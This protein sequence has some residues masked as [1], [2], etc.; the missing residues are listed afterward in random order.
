MSVISLC[1]TVGANT[2]IIKCDTA[3]GKPLVMLIGGATFSLSDYGTSTAF[4]TALLAAIK[5]ATGSS[6]KLYPFPA[7]EGAASNTEANKTATTGYGTTYILSEGRPAYTFD[8]FTG[9]NTE[10]NLRKFNKATVPVFIFDDGGNLWGKLDASGKF[11]GINAQ[12]FTTGAGFND[13][14]A[15]SPVKVNVNFTSASDFFDYA[16]YVN[17]D[18]NTSDLEGLLDA[19]LI[20]KA[21]HASSAYK[22]GV[23]VKNASLGN[24][25]DLYSTYADALAVA[26][27]WNAKNAATGANIAITTVAKDA[28]L[29][30][31]TV[32]LDATA[33]GALASG[34]KININ[35]ASPAALAAVDVD[36][37][38]GMAIQVTK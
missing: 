15:L 9:T 12:I 30:A 11:A 31:W 21:T 16:A 36:G 19:S 1:G 22:I 23:V 14:S 37:I 18:F 13:G 4:K 29:E 3:R 17:T 38:E 6:T 10:K 28:V 35:L 5:Q 26:N 27:L 24:D 2:G 34:A 33:W 20:E 25:V 8:V 7:F 32:T